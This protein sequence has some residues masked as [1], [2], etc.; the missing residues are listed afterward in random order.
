MRYFRGIQSISVVLLSALMLFFSCG[1]SIAAEIESQSLEYDSKTFTY[2]A[3]GKVKV[4]RGQAAIEADEARYNEKTSVITANGNVIYKDPDVVIKAEKA[5]L[6]M[7][8]KT[9]RLYNAEI[10]S[11]KD[12]F[13]ISGLEIEKKGEKEY[14]IKNASFTTCDAPVPE[15][16]F[17]GK[18]VNAVAG[19]RLTASG[20][21]FRIKDKP[22][23]YSP[24]F[25]TSL[26]NERKS[27]L[28]TPDIGYI[29]S[30]GIY[31]SQPFFWAI[32]ENRDITFALDYFSKRGIGEEFEYRF[33][34]INGAKGDLKAYHIR[35]KYFNRDLLDVTGVLEQGDRSGKASGYINMNYINSRD[36]YNDYNTL[37]GKD[38]ALLDPNSYLNAAAQ[39]VLE[40]TGEV[41]VQFDNSR[42]YIAGRYLIDLTQPAGASHTYQKIPEI[43]YFARPVNIGPLVFSL[44]S[45]FSNFVSNG[46]SFG[47]RLDIYPRFTNSFGTDVVITQGLGLRETAYSLA[48]SADLGASPH[49]ESF[50]YSINASTRLKKN[51]G[52]VTHVIEPSIG[53]SIIPPS[54]AALTLFDS[55]E[56]YS[57]TSRL[58]LALLNRFIDKNGEFITIRLTQSFDSYNGSRPLLPIKIEAAIQRPIGARGEVSYN[59]YT[60]KI[61]DI[62]SDMGV[63]INDAFLSIG[64]RYNRTENISFY[65]AGVNY[66]F[67]KSLSSELYLWYDAKDR[68]LND[69]LAKLTYTQQCWGITTAFTKRQ[70]DYGVSVLFNLL[71]LGTVKF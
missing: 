38:L 1:R 36:F 54:K 23:L 47:Q 65:S 57:K 55:T 52:S 51:Y 68:G 53:Y 17:N 20:V 40:S 44:S 25:R 70:N 4:K 61:E 14:S 58:D 10:F 60:G 64:E 21:T 35:D 62:N 42:L 12:N 63:S 32:S 11:I 7:E 37:I 24:Y 71:G 43:G 18:E 48:D 6:N 29:K 67:S 39:R 5:E 15:W 59:E 2:I 46:K 49:R 8:A 50:D 45:G 27:G 28:L 69:A 19:D 34:E 56:L 16:C 41:S 13:H 22:V 33:V 26:S 3:S 9:G 66:R 30:K 31:L